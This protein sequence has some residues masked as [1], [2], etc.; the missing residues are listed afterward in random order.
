MEKARKEAEALGEGDDEELIAAIRASMATF[1][2][3]TSAEAQEEKERRKKMVEE[4]MG[5]ATDEVRAKMEL[6]FAQEL[7]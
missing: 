5:D 3:E 4:F 7:T 2:G 6:Y 1:E